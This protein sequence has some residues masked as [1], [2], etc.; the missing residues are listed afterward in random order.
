MTK[1]DLMELLPS[2]FRPRVELGTILKVAPL[3][4]GLQERLFRSKE[5]KTNKD[6]LSTLLS[7]GHLQYLYSHFMGTLRDKEDQDPN[8][9]IWSTLAHHIRNISDTESIPEAPHGLS[10]SINTCLRELAA[11]I[12]VLWS[13]PIYDKML[14]YLLR[15]LLRLHLAPLR[16][17]RYWESRQAAVKKKDG[18]PTPK[19]ARKVRK[20]QK[21]KIK[22][23]CDQLANASSPQRISKI[24]HQL[25]V[26]GT[27]EAT[28]TSSP[29]WERPLDEAGPFDDE[30]DD[31]FD[32]DDVLGGASAMAPDSGKG[33]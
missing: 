16:E 10:M 17:Q 21:S 33:N 30:S 27:Q 24:C 22:Q 11:N 19:K 6:D 26:F 18:T 12:D 31:E 20:A 3:P 2:D 29:L 32:D 8:H 13:G 7:Q 28:D 5:S 25:S 9:P 4:P 1:I 15:I 14:D 23:L